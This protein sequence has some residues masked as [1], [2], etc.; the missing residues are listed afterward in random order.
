MQFSSVENYDFDLAN[1]E[2]INVNIPVK[3]AEIAANNPANLSG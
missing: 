2:K 3:T 1:S